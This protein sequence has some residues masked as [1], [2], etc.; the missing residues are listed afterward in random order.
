MGKF[1]FSQPSYW[2]CNL[3]WILG[4]IFTLFLAF[5]LLLNLAIKMSA[6]QIVEKTY[7]QLANQILTNQE[8]KNNYLQIQAK[9]QEDPHWIIEMPPGIKIQAQ[10]FNYLSYEEFQDLLAQKAYQEF[11]QENKKPKDNN[12]GIIS[13]FNSKNHKILRSIF[14]I[15]TI[16]A[17]ILLL[18]VLIF[19]YGWDK[20]SALGQF[21]VLAI[22]PIIIVYNEL[23]TALYQ[24]GEGVALIYQLILSEIQ[25]TINLYK[26]FLYISLAIIALGLV[27]FIFKKY[28]FSRKLNKKGV[29]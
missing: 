2:R 24:K 9:A 23:S 1:K 29:L 27:S 15:F 6:P 21:T 16:V 4:I 5:L 3:K 13:Y 8:F 10:E 12:L 22:L 19:A 28:L 7:S 17:L 14:P 11:Y 25:P 20:L 26:I 18:G